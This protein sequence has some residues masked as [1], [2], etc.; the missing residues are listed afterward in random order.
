[1]VEN[2]LLVRANDTRNQ[3]LNGHLVPLDVLHY[4]GALRRNL[5][6]Q[7]NG[8]LLFGYVVAAID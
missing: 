8:N 3:I 4:K 7:T 1:M 5:G 6:Y 2:A